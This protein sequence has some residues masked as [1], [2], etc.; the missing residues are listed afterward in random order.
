MDFYSEEFRKKEESDD[1]LFEAY[2]EPNEAEAIKLAKK[3]LE[4]NPEN[5]VLRYARPC[6]PISLPGNKVCASSWIEV[7]R[8]GE[9]LKRNV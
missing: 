4:L 1:L 3:A 8:S 5:I 6:I 2:D 7:L 9:I